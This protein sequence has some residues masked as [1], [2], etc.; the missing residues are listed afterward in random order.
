SMRHQPA[1][2]MLSPLTTTLL[3]A[4]TPLYSAPPDWMSNRALQSALGAPSADAQSRS[5]AAHARPTDRIVRPSRGRRE[6][7]STVLAHRRALRQG[8]PGTCYHAPRMRCLALVLALL[9]PRLASGAPITAHDRVLV[10][11]PDPD[12]EAIACGGLLQEA[13]AAGAS[14]RVVFLTS[15]DANELSFM[16]VTKH[17]VFTPAAVRQMGER[18]RRE[19][20]AAAAAFGVDEHDLVFL[21]YPDVGT[22]KLFVERFDGDPLRSLLTDATAV[23]YP[24]AFRPGAPYVGASVLADL[25]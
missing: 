21:G 15:G 17:L 5:T 22:L 18:R 10:L 7:R 9:A 1:M 25:E 16:V 19:A 20:I 14:V 2:S 6:C 11:A 3:G 23:P 13:R 4:A 24:E 12:D 8:R